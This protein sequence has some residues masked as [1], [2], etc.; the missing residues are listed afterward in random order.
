M[1]VIERAKESDGEFNQQFA[2]FPIT[3]FAPPSHGSVLV[4]PSNMSIREAV[5]LLARHNYSCAPVIDAAKAHDISVPWQEK[6]LGENTD[7]AAV[8]LI[9]KLM[10]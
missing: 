5:K 1:V 6:Y 7:R 4:L 3:L 10:L 9:F 8:L 2:E